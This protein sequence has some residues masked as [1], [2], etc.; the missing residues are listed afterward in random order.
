MSKAKFEITFTGEHLEECP[1]RGNKMSKLAVCPSCAIKVD[2]GQK[3]YFGHRIVCP[4]CKAALEIIQ[5]N[6]PL[7]DWL[8][9][10]DKDYYPGNDYLSDEYFFESRL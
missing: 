2:I 3:P 10:N 6:P 5:V 1:S 9:D 4:D 8:F 7:L